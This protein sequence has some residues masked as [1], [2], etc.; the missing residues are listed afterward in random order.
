[1]VKRIHREAAVLNIDKPDDLTAIESRL[2]V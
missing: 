1:M 2:H